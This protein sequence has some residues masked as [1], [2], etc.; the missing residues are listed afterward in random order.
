MCVSVSLS[1]LIHTMRINTPFLPSS[2]DVKRLER[3]PALQS[4]SIC[5]AWALEPDTSLLGEKRQLWPLWGK[6]QCKGIGRKGKSPGI[7][8]TIANRYPFLL[9]MKDNIRS[10]SPEDICF[11]TDVFEQMCSQVHTIG[12]SVHSW[13]APGR[14]DRVFWG[15][16]AAR[17]QNFLHSGD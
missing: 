12:D 11:R 6:G 15:W 9:T 8:R 17:I 16:A 5:N 13:Q 7:R 14:C 10:L 1:F 3:K 2:M 4:L